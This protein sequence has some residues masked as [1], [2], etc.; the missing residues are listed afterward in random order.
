MCMRSATHLALSLTTITAADW[1][2]YKPKGEWRV[3][4]REK[5]AFTAGLSKIHIVF[6]ASTAISRLRGEAALWERGCQPY[7]KSE[8]KCPVLA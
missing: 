6:W 7:M 1:L 3:A 2:I 8:V 4:L 5:E